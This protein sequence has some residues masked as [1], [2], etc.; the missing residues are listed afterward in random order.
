MREVV[1]GSPWSRLPNIHALRLLDDVDALTM[2]VVRLRAATASAAKALEGV[3]GEL[4][5]VADIFGMCERH[6]SFRLGTHDFGGV[7][8]STCPECELA[9]TP[10]APCPRSHRE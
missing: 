8:R 4:P 1:S 9:W 10:G 3:R 7:Y 2:E 6:G 5:V